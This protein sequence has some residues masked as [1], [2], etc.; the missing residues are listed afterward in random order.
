MKYCRHVTGL[1]AAGLLTVSGAAAASDYRPITLGSASVIGDG[2]TE[3]FGQAAYGWGHES[4]GRAG[5]PA[6]E[7]DNLRLGPLG[8]R[9]GHM[10]EMEFGAYFAFANNSADDTGAPDESGLEGITGFGKLQ[11]NDF[12]ALELGARAGGADDI[13]P[14]P[15]GGLDFYVNLPMQRPLMDGLLYGEI[16]YTIHDD[17]VGG[18]Y[19]NWGIGYAHPMDT[20]TNLNFELRG[21]DSPGAGSN[22]MDL[23]L[24][25]GLDLDPIHLRPYVGL[26]LYDASADLSVGVGASMPL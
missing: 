13:A 16:G 17:D 4:A 2:E 12:F 9:S 20:G 8:F 25:A 14:Y 21:D 1:C 7:Y 6:G 11:L 26:G 22:Q 24:G 15:N 19:V 18:T 23:I 3:L 10:N 5:L